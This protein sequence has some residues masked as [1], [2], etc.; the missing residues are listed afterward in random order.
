[1]K[2]NA[3]LNYTSEMLRAR[4]LRTGVVKLDVVLDANPYICDDPNSSNTDEAFRR[5]HQTLVQAGTDR[6]VSLTI[7]IVPMPGTDQDP[8]EVPRQATTLPI[9]DFVGCRV[10]HL[11]DLQINRINP[12]SNLLII[13]GQSRPDI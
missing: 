2:N 4:I 7:P 12:Y 1:M 5:L 10:E 3:G 9:E 13:L 11:R 6:W 8:H